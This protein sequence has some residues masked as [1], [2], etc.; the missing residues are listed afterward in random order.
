M[1][2]LAEFL[3]NVWLGFAILGAIVGGIAPIAMLLWF[4]YE[5]LK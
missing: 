2:K 3:G 1:N 5:I 4:L